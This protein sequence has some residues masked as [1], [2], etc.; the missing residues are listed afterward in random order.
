MFFIVNCLDCAIIERMKV[1]FGKDK[2]LIEKNPDFDI[3]KIL[4]CG[5]IFRYIDTGKSYVVYSLDKK[6]EI[7]T[8]EKKVRIVT[9]DKKYFYNFFDLDKDYVSVVEKLSKDKVLKEAISYGRGIRILKQNL[10]EVL[11]SFVIS[12]NNNIKRIQKIIFGL[13]QRFGQNRGNYYT[14]PTLDRLQ[15]MTLSDYESLGAGY[16]GKYLFNLSRQISQEGLS[17]LEKMPTAEARKQLI[18]L[19]GIGPKVA[20]CVL[21]FGMA[22]N[23]V[24]P[25]DT[26]MEKVYIDIFGKDNKT[27][28]Q[29]SSVFIQ[30]FGDLSGIAQQYLFYN[31][32]G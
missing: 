31:K 20:D 6:A 29:M 8:D 3:K 4:E 9:N 10:I 26:W 24:F 23:D 16:R 17:M 21:L 32:R 19:S 25:V 7:F 18:S 13:C 30:R 15:T 11:F 14:F 28:P 27:R 22:R 12:A 5:Q 2:I 1:S